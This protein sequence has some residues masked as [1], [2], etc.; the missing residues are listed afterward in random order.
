MDTAIAALLAPGPRELETSQALRLAFIRDAQGRL[1][2]VK[3]EVVVHAGSEDKALT[4]RPLRELFVGA[5]KPPD[6]SGE[7]SAKLM[8]FFLLLE[9]TLVS[10][11]EEDGR[12]ETD[13]EMERT[14]LELR[15][16]PDGADSCLRS[17]LRAAARLY[18]S[19]RDVSEAEYE[20]VMRRLAKSART[21]SAP[22]LSRNYLATLRGSILA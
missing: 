19:V 5:A 21:F 18:M 13:Q 4:L 12:D 11:C 8:P 9:R 22:P 7:P 2:P 20:A 16:R 1:V 15:R 3:D 6:L 10:F 17:H 14:Y